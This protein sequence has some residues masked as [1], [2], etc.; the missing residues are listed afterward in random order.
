MTNLEKCFGLLLL[1]C[2]AALAGGF[3]LDL[4]IHEAVTFAPPMFVLGAM[5]IAIRADRKSGS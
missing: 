4:P 5:V 2:L 1:C 3:A